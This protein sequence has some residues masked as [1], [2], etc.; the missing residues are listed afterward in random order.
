MVRDDKAHIQPLQRNLS[1]CK[2]FYSFVFTQF[3]FPKQ[4]FL[5]SDSQFVFTF[6]RAGVQFL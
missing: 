3:D 6:F 2:D 1:D 4:F 5:F